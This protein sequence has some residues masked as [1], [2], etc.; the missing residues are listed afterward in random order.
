[1][2]VGL[3]EHTRPCA[4]EAAPPEDGQA[5]PGLW[6][7]KGDVGGRG[8]AEP[9]TCGVRFLSLPSYRGSWNILACRLGAGE[10]EPELDP[11]CLPGR[12][13][14]GTLVPAAGQGVGGGAL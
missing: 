12:P 14:R 13:K 10:R 11:S 4:P 8:M 3:G 7:T 5:H 6:G 9:W 2:W 1:M